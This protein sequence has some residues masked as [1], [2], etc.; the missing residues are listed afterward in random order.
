MI[1]KKYLE[2]DNQEAFQKFSN[3][4]SLF[5]LGELA[6][7]S[8]FLI[9]TSDKS[10]FQLILLS[11]LQFSLSILKLVRILSLRSICILDT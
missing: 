11:K 6:P 7:D 3:D 5:V 10:S 9:Y 4:N 8:N 1:A 2:K